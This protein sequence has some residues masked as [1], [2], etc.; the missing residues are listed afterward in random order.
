VKHINNNKIYKNLKF[1]NQYSTLMN[2]K[3]M[4]LINRNSKQM[5]FNNNQENKEINYF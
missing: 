2:S 1:N 4:I 5:I 3:Q